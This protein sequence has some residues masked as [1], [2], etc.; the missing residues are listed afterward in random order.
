MI[1]CRDLPCSRCPNCNL[2]YLFLKEPQ[3]NPQYKAAIPQTSTITNVYDDSFYVLVYGNF[4]KWEKPAFFEALWQQ[5]LSYM[6]IYVSWFLIYPQN[7]YIYPPLF[8]APLKWIFV[9]II[10]NS[11]NLSFKDTCSKLYAWLQGKAVYL[12]VSFSLI[13]NFR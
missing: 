2:P 12:L 1:W 9:N 10:S 5:C 6:Y 7:P 8:I 13:R 4:V 11:F 3:T